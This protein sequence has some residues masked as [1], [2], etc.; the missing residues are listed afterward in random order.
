MCN[1]LY[2]I[3]YKKV[4]LNNNNIKNIK[5]NEAKWNFLLTSGKQIKRDSL[6]NVNEIR[7][8]LNK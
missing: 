2:L 4:D 5:I 7:K 1:S 3:L 6:S 8:V